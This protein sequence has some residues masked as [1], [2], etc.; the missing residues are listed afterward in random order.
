MSNNVRVEDKLKGAANF[1]SWKIRIT[2]ILEESE[3]QSFI[4][5]DISIPE[6]EAK[7]ATWKRRN[8]KARKIIVDFVKDHI[9]PSISNQKKAFEVFK[10]IKDMFEINNSSRLITLKNQLMNTKMNKGETI[11]SYFGKISEN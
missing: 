1:F 3:L 6:D 5:S 2:T 10:T 11:S 8:N 7:K 4:E 9:L